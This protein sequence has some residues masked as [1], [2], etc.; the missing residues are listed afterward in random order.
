MAA[1]D[2]VFGGD[3]R[4][5][6]VEGVNVLAN[7]VK[8]T[9]GPKGRNVVLERSFGAPTVTKD[10]VSV[11][12]EIELKDKLQNMGAQMVKEVASKTSD[13]AGDGTTTATVLAQAIVREGMKYV[14]AGMNPMDLK[15]G[16]DK[17][18]TALVAQLQKAS[19]AT[20]TSKE[21]AQVG[22]I[23]A[24]SDESI[25]KII[26]DAMDKVGK[27]GVITVEDG[28]SLDNELDV[29]EGMQFDRGYLSPYF[30][31]NPDKQ[32]AILENPYVLLHD[33]KVSNI[34]D[35]LPTLEQVAKSSRPL[36][37]IAED[38]EGEALATLVVNSIRGILKV[39]AVKAPGFGDRRKAMLEDIA[40][41][42]GG[43]VI[44]EEVGMTLEKVTLADLGEAKRV[45]VG[46]E[47]TTLIDGNGK[48]DD[49]EARVKQI[50]VQIEEATSDYD[51]EKL[52]ERVAKL[53]GGVAV[54]KVG[55]ATEVEMKEKKARVEDALH[56]TRAA[57]EEGIVAGGGVALLRARQAAGAIKAD[58]ADQEAGVKL[59]LKAVEAPLREIVF[60]AGGEAS[61]VINKV[62]E[63]K[64]DY[65]YNAANDTYGDMIEMGILD[66]TKVSRTALQ[67]AASVASLMLTTEAMV[68]ESPKEESAAP[69]MPGGM[70]DMGGMG[71]MGM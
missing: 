10:G 65:G 62:L 33:K 38:I 23:S 26:A 70:G 52:Q 25:G 22:T 56:A 16:I 45:E 46:K 30:I 53:A 1:K 4:A 18:V 55:A 8:V 37:I 66:P 35:L 19:K 9:L 54:I 2:V 60:N 20:T 13:N 36:L 11:A 51:R 21:I 24:N 6:M 27:E 44:A 42:T 48:G 29:V 49:I 50:R 41:L 69:A 12:K 68:A 15:R 3:A 64:G 67:N 59:V 61:V 39:C 7:A 47:N 34:R 28:K 71:G 14:A 32:V 43:K 58:N 57:V 5:R 40:I 63:G 17:A 31:N